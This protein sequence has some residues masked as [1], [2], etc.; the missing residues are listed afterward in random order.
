LQSRLYITVT[1]NAAVQNFTL[2]T[3]ASTLQRKGKRSSW[4]A[5]GRRCGS[6]CRQGEH[7]TIPS[8]LASHL[9]H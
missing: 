6:L 9:G 2:G 1:R 4:S 5:D 8:K 7:H 3:Y